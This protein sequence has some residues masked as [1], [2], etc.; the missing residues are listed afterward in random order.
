MHNAEYQGKSDESELLIIH[1]GVYGVR[2]AWDFLLDQGM[3]NRRCLPLFMAQGARD[4]SVKKA[5]NHGI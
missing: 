2:Y 3:K 4:S 5:V 1:V